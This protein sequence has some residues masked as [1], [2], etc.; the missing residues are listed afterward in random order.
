[1]RGAGLGVVPIVPALL[2]LA[3]ALTN[4]VPALLLTPFSERRTLAT[5]A[6]EVVLEGNPI[7]AR[8]FGPMAAIFLVNLVAFALASRSRVGALGNWFRGR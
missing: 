5:A 3:F 2:A 4:V 8:A 6:L 7:D 1:M